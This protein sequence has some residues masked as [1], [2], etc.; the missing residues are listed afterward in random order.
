M[1]FFVPWLFED[2]YCR[3]DGF[4]NLEAAVLYGTGSSRMVNKYL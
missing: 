3:L 2:L 4:K 1:G